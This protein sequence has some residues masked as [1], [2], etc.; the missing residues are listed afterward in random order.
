[1]ST[2]RRFLLLA[3][4]A[5]LTLLGLHVADASSEEQGPRRP[6]Q[7]KPAPPPRLDV[8]KTI[9]I[10]P[11]L[12]GVVKNTTAAAV[13]PTPAVTPVIPP[14]PFTNHQH[15]LPRLD[16]G[17]GGFIEPRLQHTVQHAFT[18]NFGTPNGLF[19]QFGQL[20]QPVAPPAP[21]PPP[22]K[23][24]F[25]NPKVEPGKVN[26]HKSFEEARAASAMSKKPILVFQMMGKLDDQFC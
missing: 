4:L 5:G 22:V 8:G 10:E 13:Q 24:D 12:A 19:G 20:K 15:L 18:G 3:G 26:W 1:M 14:S 2:S 23:T 25:V 17:K 9:R 16:V 21:P 11:K 7:P 6:E